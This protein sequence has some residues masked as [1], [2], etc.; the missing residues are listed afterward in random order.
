MPAGEVAPLGGAGVLAGVDDDHAL[1]MLDRE[2]VDRERLRPLA[3]DDC[4]QQAAPAVADALAPG[5]GE[6][7]RSGLDRVD[8]HFIAPFVS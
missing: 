8:L 5:A 6:G 7:D 2:G 4:M 3:V 1:G